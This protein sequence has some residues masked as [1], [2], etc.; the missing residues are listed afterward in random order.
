[1]DD[2][3]SANGSSPNGSEP[4]DER[5]EFDKFKDL[6]RRLLTVPSEP[7]VVASPRDLPVVSTEVTYVG[8]GKRQDEVAYT[9][10]VGD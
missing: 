2:P 6:T 7:T 3:G 5:S 4:E 10:R 8:T 9:V 1:M